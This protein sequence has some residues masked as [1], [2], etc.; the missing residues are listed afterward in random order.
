MRIGLDIMGGD[1]APQCT[2][3]GAILAH[4]LLKHE[5]K[6]VLIGDEKII[7]NELQKYNF[8]ANKIE[9]VHADS[10]IEM[11]EHPTKAFKSKPDSSIAVGFQMLSKGKIDSFSSAGNSGA[12]LVGSMHFIGIVE[13]LSR[14]ATAATFPRLGGGKNILLD[15]GT[16]ID[17][18]PEYLLQFAFLGKLYAEHVFHIQDPKVGL[19]NIGTEKEKGNLLTRTAYQLFEES[20]LS[21]FVGNIE[22]RDL[23]KSTADVIVCDGFIGN[24]ILKQTESFFKIMHKKGYTDDYLSQFNYENYGGTPILGANNCLIK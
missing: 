18:K 2:I 22:S 24:V 15:V 19:L 4:D 5:D 11:G 17:C 21:N 10:V 12:M 1:F 23:L 13:G 6:I 14:P 20:H 8:D 16:N 7:R 9:V 3:E